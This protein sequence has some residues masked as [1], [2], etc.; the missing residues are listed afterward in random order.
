MNINFYL[1]EHKNNKGTGVI[2]CYV[3][4]NYQTITLSTDITIKNDNW[5]KKKQRVIIGYKNAI[6]IN[7][8]L[9][10]V[11]ET[12]EMIYLNE[13]TENLNIGVSELFAKIKEGFK[14]QEKNKVIEL[15]DNYL[16]AI[17]T[18]RASSFIKRTKTTR[19][20]IES[21]NQNIYVY[22]LNKK[23]VDSFADYLLSKNLTNS[24]ISNMFKVL[25]ISIRWN[26]NR[27]IEPFD[28]GFLTY[29]GNDNDTT[30]SLTLDEIKLLI[31]A[32]PDNDVE[33]IDLD[34]F[35]FSCFTGLRF[36]DIKNFNKNIIK[37][38]FIELLQQKTKKKNHIVILTPAQKILDRYKDDK[39]FKSVHS[40]LTNRRLKTIAKRIRLNRKIMQ[41]T[42]V[43]S[44]RT[45][46]TKPLY[47]VLNFHTARRSFATI[48]T[49]GN[50]NPD[51]I[52]AMTGH[53]THREFE[54]YLLF[55]DQQ[56]KQ[57]AD[58]FLFN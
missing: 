57:V 26:F 40:I 39:P 50:I 13:T 33:R 5:D 4:K 42:F 15:I 8:K 53:R 24:T 48:L 18:T 49:A 21:Y 11:R 28:I 51:L 20:H 52:K 1:I 45:E 32:K 58:A 30:F 19:N 36:S 6:L 27:N 35:L 9:D 17:K 14:R 16:K 10:K 37:N 12:I 44:K 38:G 46:T 34:A 54:K 47:D 55:N 41:T 56:L 43:G 7:K 25:R 31:N 29:K 3:R 23:F 22:D 2:Y